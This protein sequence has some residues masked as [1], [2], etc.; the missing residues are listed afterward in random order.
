M[1]IWRRQPRPS[2]PPPAW[3]RGTQGAIPVT[4]KAERRRKLGTARLKAAR[5]SERMHRLLRSGFLAIL[6]LLVLAVITTVVMRLLY[7]FFAGA[8]TGR[9]V[10][11][12]VGLAVVVVIWLNLTH[13]RYRAETWKAIAHERDRELAAHRGAGTDTTVLD[14]RTARLDRVDPPGPPPPAWPPRR[15]EEPQGFV[16]PRDLDVER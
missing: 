2:A 16:D 13:N 3:Q 7:N 10:L 14:D 15:T 9:V 6:E 11:Q 1:P 4:P 12:A 5:G 8:P